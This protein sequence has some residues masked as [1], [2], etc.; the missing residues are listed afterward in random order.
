MHRAV[1][2]WHEDL[3]AV[4]CHRSEAYSGQHD[5]TE[6]SATESGG[7]GWADLHVSLYDRKK[8]LGRVKKTGAGRVAG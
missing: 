4:P 6:E 3:R 2:T 8:P 7:T 1:A 5:H